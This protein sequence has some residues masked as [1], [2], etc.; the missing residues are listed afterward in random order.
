MCVYSGKEEKGV[1]SQTTIIIVTVKN[2]IKGVKVLNF[3]T[4]MAPRISATPYY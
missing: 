3:G 2:K 1:C 4:T